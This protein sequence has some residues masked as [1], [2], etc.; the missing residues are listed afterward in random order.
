MLVGS[1]IK[2]NER[3]GDTV[4]FGTGEKMRGKHC[5]QEGDRTRIQMGMPSLA[6]GVTQVCR[7]SGENL[8]RKSASYTNTSQR[9]VRLLE[10]KGTNENNLQVLRSIEEDHGAWGSPKSK[11]SINHDA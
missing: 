3:E 7:V 4:N 10:I 5:A 1:K 6:L 2:V 9:G 11:H 8:V